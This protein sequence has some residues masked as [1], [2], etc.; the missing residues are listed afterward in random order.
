MAV[1]SDGRF[2][3][4]VTENV[5]TDGNIFRQDASPK[6]AIG[7]RLVR[8]SRVFR[9]S[10]FGADTNRGVLVATDADESSLV[11]SDN[12]VVAPASA[13][14][15][16]DGTLGSKFVEITLAAVTANQFAGGLFVTTDDVGEGYTYEIK[17]NTAT[18]DPA[19]G[20]FRLELH[21]KLQV[22]LDATTDIA[23]QGHLN[24]NL[25][26]ATEDVD[27]AVA[28]VSCSTMDVS[29][30]AYGWIQTWG[31]CGILQDGTI[32]IGDICT[33]SDSVDGAV[34]VAGGGDTTIA[35][36]VAESYVGT[37]LI[38]GDSGGHGVFDLSIA[39]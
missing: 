5:L 18:D 33:L 7:T 38:A 23:I 22:A 8:G 28:G 35:D 15:T 39:P 20:N 3:T 11:D 9:Y 2:F 4:R 27:V 6:Y 26:L 10:H 17:G 31:P 19:S 16:T 14:T 12:I 37:C 30:A 13:A 21:Q 25:E 24:A 32:A 1:P 29:A 36:L 34:Q